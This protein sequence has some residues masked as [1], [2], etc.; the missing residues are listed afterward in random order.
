MWSKWSLTKPGEE[1]QGWIRFHKA[2]YYVGPEAPRQV[3]FLQ[4]GRY[5][6]VNVNEFGIV[7]YFVKGFD[8]DS[9]AMRA[10]EIATEDCFFSG[11]QSLN[12][13]KYQREMN[14]EAMDQY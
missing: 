14:D 9:E 11:E 10:A 5:K 4:K 6:L 1:H 12:F 7:D 13:E 3:V 8:D 2:D